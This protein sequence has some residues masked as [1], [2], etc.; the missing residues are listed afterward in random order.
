MIIFLLPLL[1]KYCLTD[2]ALSTSSRLISLIATV[3]CGHS[4]SRP[5]T[6]M[7]SPPKLKLE[8]FNVEDFTLGTVFK[9]F[10]CTNKQKNM[11]TLSKFYFVISYVRLKTV[12][13]Y[14]RVILSCAYFTN[15][16]SLNFTQS[17][18]SPSLFCVFHRYLIAE[19][20][21]KR[22]ISKLVLRIKGK[23]RV[24]KMLSQ[25]ILFLKCNR[26]WYDLIFVHCWRINE[27]DVFIDA[28]FTHVHSNSRRESREKQKEKQSHEK[29]RK[30]I[31]RQQN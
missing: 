9:P 30:P 23:E 5:S 8:I 6:E 26:I 27:I 19:F 14:T 22:A 7:F 15:I 17:V 11:S 31:E 21:T 29:K 1:F 10:S 24:R 28:H 3:S 13:R 18:L 16:W 20:Y 25:N 2:P 12:G 4:L